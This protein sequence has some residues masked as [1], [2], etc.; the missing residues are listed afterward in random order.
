MPTK[1]YKISK[2]K[3]EAVCEPAVTYQRNLSTIEMSSADKWNPHSTETY[4]EPD[5]D[6]HNA[7]SMEVVKERLHKH[8]NR[9][10][11]KK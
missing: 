9:L 4:K 7:V 5:D 2:P 1:L 6:L 3:P 10:F 8:I 11:E